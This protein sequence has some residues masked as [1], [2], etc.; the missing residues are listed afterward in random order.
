MP[1]TTLTGRI[2]RFL[3]STQNQFGGSI[4]GPIKKDKLF[5][6]GNYEGFRSRKR[7][8]IFGTVPTPLMKRGI[9]TEEGR[10]I[11]DPLTT[12]ALIQTIL[13]GS[14]AIRFPIT[15]SRR[16]DSTRLLITLPRT[17]TL[18]LQGRAL[19]AISPL[20]RRTG[21]S[22][23]NLTL[24]STGSLLRKIRSSDGSAIRTRRSFRPGAFSIRGLCLGLGTIS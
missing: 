15:P 1:R 22:A 8:T 7:Q 13:P 16:S 3:L 6:F 5:F 14:S 19:S 21:L 23:I 18:I 12:L 17:S 10:P 9:F 2:F 24:A 20:Q 4:G 11:F